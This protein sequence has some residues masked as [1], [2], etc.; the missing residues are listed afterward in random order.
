MASRPIIRASRLLLR[1]RRQHLRAIRLNFWASRQLHRPSKPLLFASRP[2]LR[3]SRQLIRASRQLIRPSRQL[4]W[5]IRLHLWASG[6][7]LRAVNFPGSCYALSLFAYTLSY[8]ELFRAGDF[9]NSDSSWPKSI[10][11]SS[12]FSKARRGQHEIGL[13]LT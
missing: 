6:Q 8:I 11:K 12:K 9:N 5:A 1:A 4:L 13:R 2:L 3:A 7:L 10:V